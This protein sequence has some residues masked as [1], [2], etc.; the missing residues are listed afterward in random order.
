MVRDQIAR[1]NLLGELSYNQASSNPDDPS[2]L[3]PFARCS[4]RVD[5]MTV[6]VTEMAT[7]QKR[8]YTSGYLPITSSSPRSL[9]AQSSFP[10]KN[11]S[12]SNVW[13][14]NKDS[15]V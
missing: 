4:P 11:L 5:N 10:P 12:S 8:K 13:G 7:F 15:K 6:I 3:S 9:L 2:A 1:V 14:I